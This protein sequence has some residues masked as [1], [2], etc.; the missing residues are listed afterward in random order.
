MKSKQ[1]KNAR[2]WLRRSTMLLSVLLVLAILAGCQAAES[3]AD[4]YQQGNLTVLLCDRPDL[5]GCE[6]LDT[7]NVS[8][9]PVRVNSEDFPAAIGDDNLQSLSVTCGQ[10]TL[11]LAAETCNV[12]G[13]I[14]A[15]HCQPGETLEVNSLGDLAGEVSALVF[16]EETQTDDLQH[17]AVDLS[18][19]VS[20]L[21]SGISFALVGFETGSSGTDTSANC[22]LI[23]QCCQV[24]GED[25]D[26]TPI[27]EVFPGATEVYWTQPVNIST[28]IAVALSQLDNCPAPDPTEHKELIA[29]AHHTEVDLGLLPSN[30]DVS[31]YWYFEP[32]IDSLGL[33]ELDVAETRLHV[34]DGFF[35]DQVLRGIGAEMQSA[36]D[37]IAC[38]ILSEIKSQADQTLQGAGE[39]ILTDN[40]RLGLTIADPMP[41]NPQR[42][43]GIACDDYR[44]V[45]PTILF[46]KE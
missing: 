6:F 27:E 40:V 11:V 42:R 38:Q 33:V 44:N 41:C 2:G 39:A 30:Y 23:P 7:V 17:T 32:I 9:G 5:D 3:A 24:E 10:P 29:I 4:F 25:E 34:E 16:S 46:H 21:H 20:P 15:F 45:P 36:G 19:A 28:E 31:M 18:E 43:L 13:R 37:Q 22:S 26:G 1:I 8:D 35:R 12:R 14:A